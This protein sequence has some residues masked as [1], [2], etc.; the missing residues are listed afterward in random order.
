VISRAAGGKPLQTCVPLAW[1]MRL[2]ALASL[3]G[4]GWAIYKIDSTP[5]GGGLPYFLFWTPL[6]LGIALVFFITSF[7]V[8]GRARPAGGG[9][10]APS[11]GLNLWMHALIGAG[12]VALLGEAFVIY[13]EEK[14]LQALELLVLSVGVIGFRM[15]VHRL[16]PRPQRLVNLW[17][18]PILIALGIGWWWILDLV[19]SL[20][21]R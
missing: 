14:R 4:A 5:D 11:R 10:Q 15:W 3:A 1:V 18:I 17:T 8:G 13:F 20:F 19:L 16:S 12:V 21:D 6:F 7:L 2:G 9:G